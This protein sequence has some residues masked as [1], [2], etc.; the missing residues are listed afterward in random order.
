MEKTKSEK[1]SCTHVHAY[2]LVSQAILAQITKCY[3]YF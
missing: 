1:S 2:Q 3:S